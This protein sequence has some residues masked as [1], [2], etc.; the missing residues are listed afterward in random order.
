MRYLSDIS[1]IST[2]KCLN[3]FKKSWLIKRMF[4]D[5]NGIRL[6][7]FKN[8]IWQ[9]HKYLGIKCTVLNNS[10]KEKIKIN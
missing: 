9:M 8:D 7:I 4:F 6:E 1:F 5:H 3:I 10:T 2:Q